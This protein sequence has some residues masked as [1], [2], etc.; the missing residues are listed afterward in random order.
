MYRNTFWVKNTMSSSR[1]LQYDSMIDETMFIN[2][3]LRIMWD[4]K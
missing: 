3:M 4:K 2:D 1:S